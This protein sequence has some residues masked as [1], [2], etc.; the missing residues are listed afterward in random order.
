[1]IN[2]TLIRDL[3]HQSTADLTRGD[4]WV[5]EESYALEIVRECIESIV[6]HANTDTD[7]VNGGMLYAVDILKERFGV[8]DES[9]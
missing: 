3:Y 5:W 7:L 4:A 1:M 6:R 8:N 9:D 2:K